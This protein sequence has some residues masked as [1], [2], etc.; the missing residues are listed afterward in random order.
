MADSSRFSL[1]YCSGEC[2]VWI[3]MRMSL[4][5]QVKRNNKVKR[6]S[7][8]LIR[9]RNHALTL[10]VFQ[11]VKWGPGI[12]NSK[13][14]SDNLKFRKSTST[15]TAYSTWQGKVCCTVLQCVAVC[16]SVMQCFVLHDPP[17]LYLALLY[18][19][20]EHSDAPT[21]KIYH[22]TVACNGRDWITNKLV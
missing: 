15:L 22:S 18:M 10:H 9:E 17:V 8:S 14:N 20:S 21:N 16:S 2:S 6:G 12:M 13:T 3:W 1:C 5:I 19:K 11:V 7:W 4:R